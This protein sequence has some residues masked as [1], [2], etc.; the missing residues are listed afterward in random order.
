MP[1]DGTS[2]NAFRTARKLA[3]PAAGT[4]AAG[5]HAV[6]ANSNPFL[7]TGKMVVKTGPREYQVYDGTVTTC[8]LPTPDWLL[9]SAEF[10]IDAEKARLAKDIQRLDSEIAKSN[11][12]LGNFGPNTPAAVLAQDPPRVAARAAQLAALR[13]QAE[14]LA[15]I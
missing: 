11:A 2:P 9:S 5:Q 4:Q 15:K 13:E 10:S 7:F 1:G 3:S 6:Y 12:K 8:Q 14:R